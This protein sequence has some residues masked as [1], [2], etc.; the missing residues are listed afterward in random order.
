MCGL[1]GLLGED[2]HWSD[3]VND[4]PRR[5]ARQRRIQVLNEVLR[6][7]RIAVAD[8]QGSGYL[9]QGATGK[10]VLA[11]GLDGVWDGVA[12]LLGRVPDPLDETLLA[13]WETPV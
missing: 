5:Q 10:Q 7:F 3:P 12:S 2:V 4:A 9:L 11:S 8:F 13:R 1:C 6:P